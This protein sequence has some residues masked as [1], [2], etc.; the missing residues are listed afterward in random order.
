MTTKD[1]RN[2]IEK[3]L[4]NSIRCLLP[5]YWWKRLFHQVADTIDTINGVEIVGS[6][7]KLKNLNAQQG[8]LASVATR[9]EMKISECYF[10]T[11]EDDSLTEAELFAKLTPVKAIEVSFPLPDLSSADTSVQ[12]V[13]EDL[14]NLGF[15]ILTDG[16]CVAVFTDVA[17]VTQKYWIL[18]SQLIV[19]AVNNFL[20]EK[21][22]YILDDRED[23]G[24][25]NMALLDSVFTIVDS[26]TDVYVKGLAWERLAKEG[27]S[28]SASVPS[29]T[30]Y[31][32]T[33]QVNGVTTMADKY[34]NLNKEEYAKII[35]SQ[36]AKENYLLQ[37]V[38]LG[39]PTEEYAPVDVELS[40]FSI[41]DLNDTDGNFNVI[42]CSFLQIDGANQPQRRLVSF[43]SDGTAEYELIPA[44]DV[45]FLYYADG[46][47]SLSTKEKAH[48]ASAI[49]SIK[50]SFSSSFTPSPIII[51]YKIDS[52]KYLSLQGILSSI[53][54]EGDGVSLTAFASDNVYFRFN[55]DLAT[56]E[57]AKAE[58]IKTIDSELSDTSENAVQNKVV[59][60]KLASLEARIAALEGK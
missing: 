13:S 14:K 26:N 21:K 58:V 24:E 38:E 51:R 48:N 1:L 8:S 45:K 22:F 53:D 33:Y 5:S 6:E 40:W 18:T 46:V 43:K 4:G 17:V 60:A 55:Y 35:A 19:D 2:N 32:T 11:Q 9:N 47:I 28:G 15:L 49:L 39:S 10:P 12:L 44:G 50:N 31:Y 23:I 42:V 34:I 29:Y 41:A 20:K 36:K 27:E 25:E 57:P 3:V 30:L 37:V 52:T 16:V 54:A 56:G 59:T 7:A